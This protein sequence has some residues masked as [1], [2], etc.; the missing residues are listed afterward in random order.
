ML[1]ILFFLCSLNVVGQD[2]LF[3]NAAKSINQDSLIKEQMFFTVAPR[4][5]MGIH[6]N[7]YFEIGISGIHIDVH[8]IMFNSA[9]V[10]GAMIFHQTSHG[11]SFDTHGFKVGVQASWA[12]F[13]WGI[14]LK[15]LSFQNEEAIYIPL[16]FGLS[17]LDCINIEYAVNIG[18]ISDDSV[19]QSKHMIGINFS[20]NRK[21]YRTIKRFK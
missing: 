7:P 6:H 8:H 14:E 4:V 16:K 11:S 21:I 1:F 2:S 20:M 12:I 5:G 9:S 17:F 13:M 18:G 15:S 3:V 10:Y 19:I